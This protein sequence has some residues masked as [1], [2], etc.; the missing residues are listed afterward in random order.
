M[1]PSIG[2]DPT[3]DKTIDWIDETTARPE[4][5]I[6]ALTYRQID[7]TAR[8]SSPPPVSCLPGCIACREEGRR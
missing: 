6:D 4:F 1:T 8:L 7:T 2:Q 3:D 5:R